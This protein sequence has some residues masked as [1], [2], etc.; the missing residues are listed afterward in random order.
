MSANANDPHYP[1]AERLIAIIKTQTTIVKAGMELDSV[2]NLVA[3]K[4]Q[5]LTRAD[6]AIVEMA[7][8]GEMVYRAVSG[9]ASPQ[10]GLRLNP[11]NSLSGLCVRTGTALI[12][13]D[14]DSDPRVNREA[15][16]KIGLHS[17]V[18]VPLEYNDYAIGVLKV[19]SSKAGAFNAQD[20]HTLE[21]LSELIAATMS[22]A[23]AYQSETKRAAELFHRA[24]HD[25]LTGLA[26]RALFYDRARKAMAMA[27]REKNNLG[28]VIVDM[29]GLKVINDT[30]GHQAGDAVLRELGV[31]LLKTTRTSDTVARLGGDEFG[32]LLAKVENRDAAEI[33]RKRLITAIDA[34]FQFEGKE[35][36]LNASLGIALFPDDGDMLET[37]L[38]IADQAMYNAKRERKGERT[39]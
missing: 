10:L 2:I 13:D 28:V 12:S 9:I 31:R 18:V 1:S 21:L 33:S 11:S 34:P 27:Q 22:H 38:S 35:I 3:G 20:T 17:M 36:P 30:N 29:D 5:E 24:T 37:L 8:D 25:S 14:C 4:A 7:E 16:S 23:T 26:N 39:G 19:V 32:V 15:C 6:G